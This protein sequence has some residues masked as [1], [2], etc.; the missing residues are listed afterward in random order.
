MFNNAIYFDITVLFLELIDAKQGE[1]ITDES[2]VFFLDKSHRLQEAVVDS[3]APSVN[4]R[5][6]IDP[7]RDGAEL[8]SLFILPP[9]LPL[10][11]SY[12]DIW[13][14]SYANCS[15]IIWEDG[16]QTS[17]CITKWVR[18]CTILREDKY[19]KI[20]DL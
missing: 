4:M 16:A 6:T 18:H 7:V 8:S 14:D 17:F 9:S 13:S 15:W 2:R 3:D 5:E 1:G 19:S 10:S 20:S 11:G 12:S